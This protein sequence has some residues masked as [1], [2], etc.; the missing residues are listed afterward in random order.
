MAGRTGHKNIVADV[1][2]SKKSSSALLVLGQ[3]ISQKWCLSSC[4]STACGDYI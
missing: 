2:C 4:H 1:F 3:Q